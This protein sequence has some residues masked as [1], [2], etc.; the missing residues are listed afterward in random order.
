MA[1][2]KNKAISVGSKG[3]KA[4]YKPDSSKS[5][6]NTSKGLTG[7]KVNRSAIYDGPR[8]KLPHGHGFSTKISPLH[9]I[10]CS[11]QGLDGSEADRIASLLRVS[12]KEMARLL[13][14]SVATFHRRSKSGRLDAATSERLLMLER[15]AGHGGAVF[16]DAGKFTRWLRRPLRLLGDHEPLDLMDSPTGILLVEDMLGRIEHGVFS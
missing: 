7:T 2:S 9:L 15:L 4:S 5:I 12:D 11:R 13:N 14:Q 6:Y 16:Q 10:N 1:I 8:L 3:T